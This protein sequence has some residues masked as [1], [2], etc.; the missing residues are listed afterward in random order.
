MPATATQFL[1]GG[2][3]GKNSRILLGVKQFLEINFLAGPWWFTFFPTVVSVYPTR[4][5]TIV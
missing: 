1:A 3:F 2:S 4:L 5:F